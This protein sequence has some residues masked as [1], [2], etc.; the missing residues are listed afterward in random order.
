MKLPNGYGSVIKHKGNRR[1]P[2]QV[3]I[4]VGF[5]DTGLQKYETLGWFAKREEGLQAL[6]DYHKEP[7]NI[8][9][10]KI[11]FADLYDIWCKERKKHN[12]P[13]YASEYKHLKDLY[14]KQFSTLKPSDLQSAIDNSNKNF[15]TREKMKILL[16][17]LYGYAMKNE[18][19]TKRQSTFVE[20][21]ENEKKSKKKPFTQEEIDTLFEKVDT[22]ENVDTV[23]I[24]IFSLI[25]VGEL[26]TIETVNVHLEE[27]Y[28]IGG[29][30]TE[31]GKNRIIPIS[32][33]IEPF[34]RSRY[35]PDNKYLICD[36]N[37]NRITYGTYKK[38]IFDILMEQL[39]MEHT[40]HECR[41]TGATLLDR[42]G[43]NKICQKMILGHS[44]GNDVTDAVYVHKEL[45]DLLEAIDLI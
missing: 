3:R 25:R 19:V 5:T 10:K 16:G 17:L 39:G 6:S 33:K 15:P 8:Q 35:N 9:D 44:L 4:T 31:A 40:P 37:G 2:Y 11:K 28:M 26:L 42:A 14:N 18:I 38:Y 45:A 13:I 36:E 27:R 43:A 22:M 7:Y 1:K 30:K 21:G 24:M 32:R 23:L 12:K 29:I 41:H 20:L 34:I